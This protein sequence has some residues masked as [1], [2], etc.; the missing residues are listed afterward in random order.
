[1]KKKLLISKNKAK[2]N[3]K[4]ISKEEAEKILKESQK[5]DHNHDHDHGEDIK[6]KKVTKKKTETISTKKNIFLPPT[7]SKPK[8]KK[9]KKVSKK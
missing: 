4:E 8:V 3:K 9:I 1:M 2:A 7:K 6:E 5:V